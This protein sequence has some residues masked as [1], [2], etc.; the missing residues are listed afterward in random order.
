MPIIE[1][2]LRLGAKVNVLSLE[3]AIEREEPTVLQ[4]LVDHGWDIN[5]TEFEDTAIQ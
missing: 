2:L 5:S 4:V 1:L 3:S